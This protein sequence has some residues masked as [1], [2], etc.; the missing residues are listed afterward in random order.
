MESARSLST[1]AINQSGERRRHAWSPRRASALHH[2]RASKR[3]DPILITEM[4]L[5]WCLF[6]VAVRLFA[7]STCSHATAWSSCDLTFDLQPNEDASK[8]DLHAEFRSPHHR[9]YMMHAFHDDNQHL[10][11]RFIPTEAGT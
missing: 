10:T 11:I 8:S 7:Q 1:H 6:L 9:T 3:N 2:C 4:S 5:R